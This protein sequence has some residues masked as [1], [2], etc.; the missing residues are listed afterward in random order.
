MWETSKYVDCALALLDLL[1]YL[2]ECFTVF[3]NVQYG[4]VFYH[5]DG[6]RFTGLV[7]APLV[8]ELCTIREAQV[9]VAALSVHAML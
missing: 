1:R 4:T 5:D 7:T 8:G 6:G 9:P 3:R 2:L